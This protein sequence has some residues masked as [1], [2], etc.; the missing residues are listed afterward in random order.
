MDI[1]NK[2]QINVREGYG[3]YSVAKKG[4]VASCTA[5]AEAAARRFAEKLWGQGTHKARMVERAKATNQVW[6]IEKANDSPL[7]AF[8][9]R[10]GL[11]A[12]D[13]ETPEGALEV[14]TGPADLLQA[15]VGAVSRH[16][17]NNV[18]L[19]CPGVPEATNEVEALDA[20]MAFEQHIKKRMIEYLADPVAAAEFLA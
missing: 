15:V 19:L 3:T 14:G 11:V 12:F 6:E 13:I 9:Y 10:S 20:V 8:V 4:I 17:Y 18:D 5:S 1:P 16:A 2:L 7:K